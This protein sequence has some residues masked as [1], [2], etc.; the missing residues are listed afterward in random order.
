MNLSKSDLICGHPAMTVRTL[1]GIIGRGS[2]SIQCSDGFGH[3]GLSLTQL[4]RL[5]LDLFE[6]GY[7]EEAEQKRDFMSLSSFDDGFPKY[8]E[9]TEL[10]YRITSARFTKRMGRKAI[11]KLIK[12]V[13]KRAEQ[14]REFDLVTTEVSRLWVFGSYLDPEVENY[15]DLDLVMETRPK[16]EVF[17]WDSSKGPYAPFSLEDA[18]LHV[19]GIR[20][21]RDEWERRYEAGEIDCR[22]PGVSDYIELLTWDFKAFDYFMKRGNS[23]ISIHGMDEFKRL[24]TERIELLYEAE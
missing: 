20:E 17:G 8:F 23:R 19:K 2:Y 14:T 18:N 12:T 21:R 3:V 16:S 24:Q 13:I 15:G 6:A 5:I 10:G 7:L 22:T 1:L 4:Y 11:D 9:L